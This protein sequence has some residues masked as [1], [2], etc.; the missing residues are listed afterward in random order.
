MFGLG[1]HDKLRGRT[2]NDVLYGGA[3]NDSLH[4]E[5][6]ADIMFGGAG[7]KKVADLLVTQWLQAGREAIVALL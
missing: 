6:G 1:G 2:G 7:D 5:L 3:D 4:G